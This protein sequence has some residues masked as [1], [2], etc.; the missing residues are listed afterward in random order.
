M[1]NFYNRQNSTNN[2]N[3]LNLKNLENNFNQK[4][5]YKMEEKLNST[6]NSLNETIKVK[7]AINFE[8]LQ[9]ARRDLIG[10]IEAIIE[11]D[12]HIKSS[13]DRLT[14]QTWLDIKNEELVHVGEL[15]ALIGYLDNSQKE[16]VEEGIN[17]FNERLKK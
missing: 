6:E 4:S 8:E 15:L 2:E 1:F 5:Q 3:N 7:A 9:K 10:E 16:Y 13:T 14:Q 11:Y 12:N 17:E